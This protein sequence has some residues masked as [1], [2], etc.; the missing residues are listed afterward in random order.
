MTDETYT[1]AGETNA[2]ITILRIEALGVLAAACALYAHQ[3]YSWQ[4]FAIFFLL[5][6]V[7]MIG[8]AFGKRVGAALYNVGH[9]YLIPAMIG[10]MGLALNNELAMTAAII[11]IA[12]IGFDRALGYGLKYPDAFKHTHLGR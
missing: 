5:P 3:G 11:W 1:D 10:A 9:S 7:S 6:D 4:T 8:Y 2:P 12:H